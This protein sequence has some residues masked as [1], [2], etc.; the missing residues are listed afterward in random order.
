MLRAVHIFRGM[1]RRVAGREQTYIFVHILKYIICVHM[2][3]YKIKHTPNV[4]AMTH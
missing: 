4:C 3:L 1:T 2:L